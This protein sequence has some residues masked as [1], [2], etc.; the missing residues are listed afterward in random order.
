[1]EIAR[2]SIRAICT[3]ILKVSNTILCWKENIINWVSGSWEF[4]D[5][6]HRSQMTGRAEHCTDMWLTTFCWAVSLKELTYQHYEIN[7]SEHSMSTSESATL[8][9]GLWWEWRTDH[10]NEWH[11]LLQIWGWGWQVTHTK[12]GTITFK[13]HV[14]LTSIINTKLTW[15]GCF[16]TIFIS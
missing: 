15:K 6:W 11:S 14:K 13:V 12:L 3:S 16:T 9:V 5:N 8:W 1:M 2:N 10:D 4:R 7:Q